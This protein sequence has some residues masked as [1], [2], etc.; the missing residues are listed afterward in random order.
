MITTRRRFIK[1]VLSLSGLPLLA[2]LSGPVDQPRF[3]LQSMDDNGLRLLPGFTSR[4]VAIE[5]K[6]PASGS[7]YLWHQAPDGGAVF[8]DLDVNNPNGW[9]YVSNAESYSVGGAGALKF[10]AA[11]EIIDAYRILDG[12]QR[13]CAGGKTPWGTW[14]SAEEVNQGLVWECHP[15]NAKPAH[16]IKAL[17]TFNHEAAAVDPKHQHIYLTEDKPDGCLY[18]T[19]FP[20]YPDLKQGT[21]QVAEVVNIKGKKTLVWHDVPNPNPTAKEKQTRH[22][23]KAATPFDGGEGM[24]YFQGQVFFTTKGDNKVWCLTTKS[25]ELSVVYDIQTSNNP[26]LSGVD[27]LTVDENGH[28][29]VAEDGGDMEIVMLNQQGWVLPIVQIMNQPGSEVTG[30]AFTS[31]GSRMYFSSQRG[32]SVSG[33]GG[34]TYEVTGPFMKLKQDFAQ[35]LYPRKGLGQ[36]ALT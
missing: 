30:V 26:I 6:A 18:R 8:D 9:I 12:T 23:V 22:Q 21:L 29:Y 31:D 27:N 20:H 34:I 11:G 16:A 25:Q 5:G 36:T 33:Y 28:I 15:N 24:W 1:Q 32:P 4:V 35:G 19:H 14:L 13:N 17:G 2:K 3:Q 10:N 7:P